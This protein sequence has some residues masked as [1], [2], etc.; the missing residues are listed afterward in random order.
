MYLDVSD[1][2]KLD[3]KQLP[4]THYEILVATLVTVEQVSALLPSWDVAL[5]LVI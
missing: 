1:C 5:F 4:N 2:I 3:L